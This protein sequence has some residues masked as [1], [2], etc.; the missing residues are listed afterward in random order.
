MIIER[1]NKTL[2]DKI[3]K[4]I[5]INH[6]K[7]YKTALPSLVASYNTS[8]HSSTGPTPSEARSKDFFNSEAFLKKVEA[9]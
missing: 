2:R 7:K 1:F 5:L 3:A 6:P 8:V 9:K 4:W